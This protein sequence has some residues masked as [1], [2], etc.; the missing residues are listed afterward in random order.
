MVLENQRGLQAEIDGD[1]L[2][3]NQ[4]GTMLPGQDCNQTL[5]TISLASAITLPRAAFLQGGWALR[6][7]HAGLSAVTAG[8]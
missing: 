8:H 6:A 2:D 5:V 3:A 1:S 7:N 4:K